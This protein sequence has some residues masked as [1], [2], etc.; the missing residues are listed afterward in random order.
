MYDIE[1]HSKTANVH[2]G[3]NFPT[4][5]EQEIHKCVIRITRQFHQAINSLNFYITIKKHQMY[6]ASVLLTL[7]QPSPETVLLTVPSRGFDVIS[8]WLRS[9]VQ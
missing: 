3:K 4:K 8:A 7:K 1:K 6:V 9:R 5:T 2:F